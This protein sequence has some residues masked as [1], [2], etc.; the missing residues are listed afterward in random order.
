M[1][2]SPPAAPDD[3]DRL[4]GLER[5]VRQLMSRLAGWVETQLVEAFDDRRRDLAA[6]RS[7]TAAELDALRTSLAAERSAAPDGVEQRVRQ[8]MN[9]LAETVEA[10]LAELTANREAEIGALRRELAAE[11]DERIMAAGS[12]TAS[13][14]TGVQ[15]RVAATDSRFSDRLAEL[16]AEAAAAG[17]GVAALTAEAETATARTEAFEQRV[18]AAMGRLS[19]SVEARLTEAASKRQEELDAFRA[20]VAARTDALAADAARAREIAGRIEGDSA[21]GGER[22]GVLEQQLKAALDRASA[23]MEA[24][25]AEQAAAAKAESGE[26]RAEIEAVVTR[27]VAELREEVVAGAN[28][29]KSGLGRTFA[30]LDAV[31]AA[32]TETRRQLDERLAA[33][34]DADRARLDAL[35]LHTRRTDAKLGELVE[36]KFAE[37][38]GERGGELEAFRADMEAAVAK[39]L[40]RVRLEVSTALE[41]ASEELAASAARMAEQRA[42]WEA[43]LESQRNEVRAATAA[44]LDAAREDVD[45]RLGGLEGRSAELHA[46]LV[47]T[48]AQT[49]SQ[50]DAM[51]DAAR[52]ELAEGTQR[53]EAARA[54]YLDEAPE[55]AVLATRHAEIRTTVGGLSERIDALTAALERAV[56]TESGAL[57]PLRS[58]LRALQDQVAELVAVAASRAAKKPAVPKKAAAPAKRAVRPRRPI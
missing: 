43:T 5:Q 34:V 39:E 44:L 11:L 16:A 46:V 7:E 20:E 56:A 30:R 41:G 42:A 19:D 18:K 48:V 55:V 1:S 14:L 13:A 37:L 25:L 53:M 17:A 33:A 31:E 3:L 49:R 23:A 28:A 24:R 36:A 54:A 29:A 51:L 2:T 26:L 58:D 47:A 10:Q 50:L 38:A 27:N 6:L 8:A 35:E 52:K 57:A 4:E 12:R 9:R 15:D 22:V 40:G 32:N 21:K 45:S